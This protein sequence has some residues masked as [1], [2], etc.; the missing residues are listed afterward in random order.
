MPYHIGALQVDCISVKQFV[1]WL[2]VVTSSVDHG[3]EPPS[4]NHTP[5]HGTGHVKM[6]CGLDKTGMS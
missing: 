4:A 3:F 1:R 2:S 6:A 5:N